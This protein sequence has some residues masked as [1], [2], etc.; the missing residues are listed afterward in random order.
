MFRKAWAAVNV[1]FDDFIRTTE[2]RH[3]VAVEAMVARA[4]A[5]GDLY[6][7]FYTG[8]YCVS[9]EAYYQERDLREG[10]CPVHE[11]EPEFRDPPLLQL[12]A[13]PP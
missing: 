1:Q 13:H 8:Y 12:V 11:T 6:D 9:C 3:R 10:K 4:E 5:S 7:G 2:R